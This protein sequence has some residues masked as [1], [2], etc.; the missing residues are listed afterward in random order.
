MAA[1]FLLSFTYTNE[2]LRAMINDPTDRRA[3]FASLLKN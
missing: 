2:T 3:R 1:R